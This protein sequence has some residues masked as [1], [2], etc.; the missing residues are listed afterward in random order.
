MP[1]QKRLDLPGVI[2]H[3]IARGLG[4]SK[5]FKGN[6]DREEFLKRLAA[7]LEKTGCQCYAWSLMPNHSHLLIA[8]WGYDELG[9]NGKKLSQLLE[10]SRPAVSKAINRGEKI[11]KENNLK[12]LS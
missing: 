11:V 3:V 12:L 8:F 7:E 10:I 4:L 9:I 1:R 2:H 6:V 5:R